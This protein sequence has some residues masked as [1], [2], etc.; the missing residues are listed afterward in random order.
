MRYPVPAHEGKADRKE[1]WNRMS[2]Q[3]DKP[4]AL[5]A[6]VALNTP[7]LPS[8]T[9]L[10]ENLKAIPGLAVDLTS[11]QATDH[12]IRFGLGKNDVGIGLMPTPIPWSNLEGPCA[13]AWW[14]PE[15]TEKLRTH[16]SHLLVFLG[17]DTGNV[18]QRHITLTHL[19]ATVAAHAD[20]A[21]ICWGSGLV[22]NPQVFIEQ[23]QNLA[24]DNL[25]LHLWI[26]FRVEPNDDGSQRLFTTGMRAFNHPEIEI[27]HSSQQPAEIFDFAYAIANYVITT[28]PTIEDGQTVGRSETEKIRA[29]RAPSMWDSTITVLRL[30]F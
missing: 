20:A 14:W 15:A 4:H 5:L 7:A 23:A 22:H 16:N 12:A 9:A 10:Q 2:P 17:G 29:T 1:P 19:S 28:N 6:M 25:P 11:V 13:T 27:P 21:G 30:D 26:D 24:A 18:V 3:A 8:A